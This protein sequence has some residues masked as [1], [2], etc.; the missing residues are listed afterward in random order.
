MICKREADTSCLWI[1]LV[2]SFSMPPETKNSSIRIVI[3]FPCKSRLWIEW[4]CLPSF[5]TLSWT[6]LHLGPDI[7]SGCSPPICLLSPCL[8]NKSICSVSLTALFMYIKFCT[9]PAPCSSTH[10]SLPQDSR[11]I[12]ITP[13]ANT[14]TIAR[15]ATRANSFAQYSQEHHRHTAPE[16]YLQC[17]PSHPLSLSSQ[18][19]SPGSSPLAPLWL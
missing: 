17:T 6:L 4:C 10:L 3:V 12:T 9:S 5:A 16:A 14:I 8:N 18:P 2:L 1:G 11:P 15:A 7:Q 13:R 19:S